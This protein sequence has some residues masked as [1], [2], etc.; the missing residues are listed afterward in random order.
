MPRGYHFMSAPLGYVFSHWPLPGISRRRYERKLVAFQDSLKANGP[1]GLVDVLSF[2]V[3]GL[4]WAN[5]RSSSCE[6]WYVVRDFAAMGALN[7]AVVSDANRE[8]HGEVAN[9][10]SGGAGALYKMRYGNLGLA[11]AR[12]ETW[13]RK[14]AQTTY[15]EFLERLSRLVADRK[16]DLWQRQMVLGPAHEFCLHSKTPVDIPRSLRPTTVRVQLVGARSNKAAATNYQ[17]LG[18]P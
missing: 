11:D 8:A 13:I 6:D 18:S 1:E 5:V 12:F 10:A 4:P 9:E 2:R 16:T 3:Q 17:R 14:P 15:Q 7:D